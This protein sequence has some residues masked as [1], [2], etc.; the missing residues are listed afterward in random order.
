MIAVLVPLFNNSF[1]VD[2]M[3]QFVKLNEATMHKATI[4]KALYSLFMNYR[5]ASLGGTLTVMTYPPGL[6]K[7]EKYLKNWPC[8]KRPGFNPELTCDN[9]MMQVLRMLTHNGKTEYAKPGNIVFKT[10]CIL[11]LTI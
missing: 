10:V 8:V 1:F 9:L 2:T 5:K 6:E 7:K 11:L 3:F 4:F